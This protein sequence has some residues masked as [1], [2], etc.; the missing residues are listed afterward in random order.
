MSEG[1]NPGFSEVENQKIFP[2]TIF[3]QEKKK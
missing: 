1:L 2:E 3:T